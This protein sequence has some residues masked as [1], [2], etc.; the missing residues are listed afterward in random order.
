MHEVDR[1][2]TKIAHMREA[3]YNPDL[4]VPSATELYLATKRLFDILLSATLLVLLAPLMALVA[5]A[6]RL[7]SPGP[8]IFRQK[9]VLGG[10]H[11]S[12][13]HPERHVFEF[14]KFR[15]M[16]HNA[17]QKLHQ[18]HMTQLISGQNAQGAALRM[19]KLAHDPR[20]TRV[21]RLLR[22]TSLDELPQLIN[23]LR[24]DMSFVGPRPPIPYEVAEYKAWHLR[25]L[26]VVQGLTGLWQVKGRNDLSFDEMVQLDIEYA[27]RRSLW[28]DAK[29]LLATIP[30][31]L[32]CRGVR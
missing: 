28:L 23:I 18:Q 13:E 2:A 29:I 10:Q 26:E 11:P 3:T 1:V 32:I 9:R 17:D 24:G 4:S 22:K 15:S 6:I 31:V 20:V 14:W 5:L 8:V 25:R 7:D 16:H 27:R 12:E 21:G 19:H 30:A